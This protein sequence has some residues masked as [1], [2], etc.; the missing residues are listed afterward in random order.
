MWAALQKPHW[1]PPKTA[2]TATIAVLHQEAGTSQNHFG[3]SNQR[4]RRRSLERF[5]SPRLGINLECLWKTLGS[6][7]EGDHMGRSTKRNVKAW[8]VT[9]AR[10]PG[11]HFHPENLVRTCWPPPGRNLPAL[12]QRRDC[13]QTASSHVSSHRLPTLQIQSLS[14]SSVKAPKWNLVFAFFAS[15]MERIL[16]NGC[17]W[18]SCSPMQ[19]K[20][21][22]L[23]VALLSIP[24]RGSTFRERKDIGVRGKT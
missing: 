14:T 1:R 9:C 16:P 8:R 17:W 4:G 20:P 3:V 24:N 18:E 7:T 15:Q 12:K 10:S 5:P 22:R 2:K 19:G 23:Q 6:R 21:K 11:K 13:L